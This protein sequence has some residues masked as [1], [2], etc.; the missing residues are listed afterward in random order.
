VKVKDT[1][2]FRTTA[3][4]TGQK[5]C[6]EFSLTNFQDF[7]R[8]DL[9]TAMET[10]FTRV[11]IVDAAQAL[12]E[13]PHVVG[14]IKIDDVRLNPIVRGM[15]THVLIE[16]SW[17]FAMRESDQTEYAYSFAGTATSNDSYPS[18]EG[19]CAQLV[20]NA[21]PSMLKKWTEDGGLA[22]MRDPKQ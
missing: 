13:T 6:A 22:A 7:V 3:C 9:K 2:T 17:G 5:G 12:P 14:D 16:M 21:I 19:G 4:T 20:E 11:E 18:F 1:W 15:F 8:R 10:Y